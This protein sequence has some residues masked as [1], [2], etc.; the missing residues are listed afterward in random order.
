[1]YMYIYMYM[2][3][4]IYTHNVYYTSIEMQRMRMIHACMYR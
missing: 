1:M 3:M 4:Y 2:Y